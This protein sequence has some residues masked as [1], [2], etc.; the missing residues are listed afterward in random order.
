MFFFLHKHQQFVGVIAGG[1]PQ[2]L[3]MQ[4]ADTG[5]LWRVHEDSLLVP[6]KSIQ[7]HYGVPLSFWTNG[8]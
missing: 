7:N 8:P 3:E 2:D 4:A 6:E 5:H 1:D